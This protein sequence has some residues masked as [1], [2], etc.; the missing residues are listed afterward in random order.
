MTTEGG[1]RLHMYVHRTMPQH[2]TWTRVTS[3]VR[4]CHTLEGQHNTIFTALGMQHEFQPAFPLT[5][6]NI[7]H[8]RSELLAT[9]S[10]YFSF[11]DVAQ[12]SGRNLSIL[13]RNLP[14]PSSG[15]KARTQ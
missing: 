15:Q 7:C 6:E 11:N 3:H 14:S 5:T 13:K 1:F 10:E 4:T 8:S 9:V 2:I 12:E